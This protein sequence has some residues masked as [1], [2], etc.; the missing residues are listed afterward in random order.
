MTNPN[1][2]PATEQDPYAS[3]LEQLIGFTV[4][5]VIIY[6]D[7]EGVDENV[8]GLLFSHTDE[9]GKEQ[10]LYTEILRDE[11]G[12]GPGHLAIEEEPT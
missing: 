6:E 1:E 5:Q 8:Y 2:R 12:N 3:H 7:G 10:V 4:K 9:S 11:E